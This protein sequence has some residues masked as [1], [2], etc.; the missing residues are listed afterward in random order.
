M[1]LGASAEERMAGIPA[2]AGTGPGVPFVLA[3]Q[4]FGI[5][6]MSEMKLAGRKWDDQDV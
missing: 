2:Y 4:A 5:L 6:E 1:L 3:L